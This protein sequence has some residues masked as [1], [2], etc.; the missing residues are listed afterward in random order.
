[1]E[2]LDMYEV[3]T[4]AIAYS[5]NA[6]HIFEYA[7]HPTLQNYKVTLLQASLPI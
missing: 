3:K 6:P 7:T 5:P 1:M 2:N 4:S